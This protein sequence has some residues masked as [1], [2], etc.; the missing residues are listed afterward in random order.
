MKEYEVIVLGG[1]PAGLTAGLYLAR[2]R[3]KSLLIEKAGFGGQIMNAEWVENFPGFPEGINGF[4]LAQAMLKQAERFGLET[5]LAQVE[6]LKL[7]GREKLV[8][9]SAGKFR[10]KAVILATG[11][12]RKKLGVPGEEEFA[13]RGVSY[14]ATCDGAFF[15]DKPVAVIGG[16]NAALNEAI[17]L[18]KFASKVFV[19]HRR[20][21]LRATRIFQER[22]YK[23]PKIKFLWKSVVQAIEGKDFVERLKLKEVG[24]GNLSSLEVSGVFISVGLKPNTDYLKGIIPLDEGGEIRVNEKMETEIPGVFAAGDVRSNSIRQAVAAAGDGAVAA[25]YARRYLEGI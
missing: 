20:D 11:S 21:E 23:E 7:E 4:D 25:F 8:T 5:L 12:E 18:T 6:A 9:T 10:A 19:I 1:G 3:L 22:A 16:G 15:R 13:G 17:H 14:C 2:D 24:S